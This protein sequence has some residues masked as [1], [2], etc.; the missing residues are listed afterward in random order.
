[1]ILPAIH[2]SSASALQRNGQRHRFVLVELHARWMHVHHGK[3]R[4][5]RDV[6]SQDLIMTISLAL[7]R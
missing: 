4:R 5:S 1:V 2:R 7:T 6:E 3:S